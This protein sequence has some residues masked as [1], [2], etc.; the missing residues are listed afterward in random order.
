MKIILA[1]HNEH[2]LVEIKDLFKDTD[3]EFISLKDLNFNKEIEENGSTFEENAY[4]KAKTI[5]DMYHLPVLSDDSGL[6]IDALNNF[7]GIYSARYANGDFIGA[8]NKILTRLEGVTNRKADFNCTICY[9]DENGNKHVFEGVCYGEIGFEMS[10]KL[11]FGYDPIFY[12]NGISFASMSLN[13]KNKISH[14]S[15]AFKKFYEYMLN[16]SKKY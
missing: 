15:I 10:G 2:K 14:R 11:G 8:M 12:V 7:P 16:T 5:Y 9:L 3:I 4:I 6:E 13:E 1:S